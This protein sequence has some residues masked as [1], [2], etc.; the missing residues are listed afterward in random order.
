MQPISQEIS[1]AEFNPISD[2][3][4]EL[5]SSIEDLSDVQKIRE[6]IKE[7]ISETVGET[8]SPSSLSIKSNLSEEADKLLQSLRL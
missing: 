5:N 4:S 2:K 8:Y 7:T 6:G 3:V 1:E